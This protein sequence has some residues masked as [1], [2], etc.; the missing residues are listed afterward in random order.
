LSKGKEKKK[1]DKKKK[2][3]KENDLPSSPRT[4]SYQFEARRILQS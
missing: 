1:K 4:D 2:R 3:K